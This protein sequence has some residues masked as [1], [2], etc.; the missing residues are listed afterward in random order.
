MQEWARKRAL[1]QSDTWR[2]HLRMSCWH[3]CT[4][5][6]AGTW[7]GGG[8]GGEGRAGGSAQTLLGWAWPSSSRACFP[9]GCLRMPPVLAF[10]FS[11][12]FFSLPCCFSFS[13]LLSF[14]LLSFFLCHI[15]CSSCFASL[16]PPLRAFCLYGCVAL[17]PLI[18]DLSPF[19]SIWCVS[20]IE[21]VI[22]L[23]F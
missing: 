2:L 17:F 5:R 6:G 11:L 14:F 4:Q 12:P 21:R 23:D 9:P 8:G 15:Y 20:I 10:R 16:S 7:G 22:S 3:Y 13:L 18:Y 19:A 1:P